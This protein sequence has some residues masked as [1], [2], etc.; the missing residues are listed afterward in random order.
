MEHWKLEKEEDEKQAGIDLKKFYDE[1]WTMTCFNR[2]C[3]NHSKS[4]MTCGSKN[5]QLSREGKCIYW[6]EF[7]KEEVISTDSSFYPAV[8]DAFVNYCKIVFRKIN[9]KESK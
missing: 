4:E 5:I 6:S 8:A 3:P 9:K 2:D 7:N 1:F